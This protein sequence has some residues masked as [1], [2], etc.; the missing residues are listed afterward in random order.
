[1]KINN[2]HQKKE[3]NQKIKVLRTFPVEYVK[4]FSKSALINIY[5]HINYFASNYN[6]L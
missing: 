1:M 2:N 4:L 6:N 3:E 5:S